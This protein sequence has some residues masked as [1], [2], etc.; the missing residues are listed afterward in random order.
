MATMTRPVSSPPSVIPCMRFEAPAAPWS[1][2]AGFSDPA[3]AISA[4]VR[5]LFAPNGLHAAVE[6][7]ADAEN[8][9][10]RHAHHGVLTR[11]GQTAVG[12]HGLGRR[13]QEGHAG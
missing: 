10:P 1:A 2:P 8:L 3:A 6:T 11:R 7:V 12:A 4:S 13:K 9:G 5:I